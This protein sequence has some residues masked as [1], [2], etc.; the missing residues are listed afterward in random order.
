M[1]NETLFTDILTRLRPGYKVDGVVTTPK[2]G[3]VDQAGSYAGDPKFNPEMTLPELKSAGITSKSKYKLE[4]KYGGKTGYA[5]VAP[6]YDKAGNRT[7]KYKTMV[8]P[9]NSAREKFIKDRKKMGK[10]SVAKSFNKVISKR[11]IVQKNVNNWIT[12]WFNKNNKK[13]KLGQYD[14][15][16]SKLKQD[17]TKESTKDK[18]KIDSKRLDTGAQIQTRTL[19]SPKGFPVFKDIKLEGMTGTDP[20]RTGL[21]K[22][23]ALGRTMDTTEP[24][25][26]KS[27]HNFILKNDPKLRKDIKSF[28]T[29]ATKDKRGLGK[30]TL[31]LEASQDWLK[32]D[33]AVKFMGEVDDLVLDKLK[34]GEL[35]RKYFPKVTNSYMDKIYKIDNFRNQTIKQLEKLAGVE[36]G[37]VNYNLRKDRRDLQ[38][39]F[40]TDKLPLALKYSGDHIVGLKEASVLKDKVVAKQVID[41]VVGK[42]FQQNIELGGTRFGRQRR[43]LTK[44]FVNKKTTPTRKN[45]IVN[46]LNEMSEKYMPGEI[47]YDLGKKNNLVITPL[48]IQSKQSDRFT[49]YAKEIDKTK[50]GRAAIKKQYGS[51]K[52]LIKEIKNVKNFAA[53]KGFELNSFAGALNLSQANI[54]IPPSVRQSLTKIVSAGKTLGKG[55]VVL[56][57]LFATMD[58]SKAMGEGLSGKESAS[59]TGQKFLQDITNL[60]RTLEDLAYVATDKG[61]FKNFGEKEN[62]LFSYEPAA[63]ADRYIQ[64]KIEATPEATKDF[65]KA[66]IDY[67]KTLPIIDDMDIPMSQSE[68]KERERAFYI[69]RGVEPPKEETDFTYDGIMGIV[70]PKGVI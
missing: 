53:K 15:A 6:Q 39:I 45:E 33:N 63:F 48:K 68:A 30:Q 55:A 28:M 12:D 49:S 19:T 5:Y 41:N 7:G 37:Y 14:E 69:Q 40:K 25:Y 22:P 51:L 57:P 29:W 27:F 21:T 13:F 31:L 32:N 56:D 50:E 26:K 3:L 34:R 4:G 58:F 10:E 24:F 61:T 47:K 8:F 2:R 62:R 43:D 11:N 46:L 66:R 1:A 9:T 70:P 17:W 38:K 67:A 64:E 60:P 16:M 44:E 35:L 42:T 59:Y 18:Y 23:L 20:A 52:N 54:D 65:R 36:P